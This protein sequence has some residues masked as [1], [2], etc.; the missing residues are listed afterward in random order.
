MNQFSEFYKLIRTKINAG[1]IKEMSWVAIGQLANIIFS[2][3]IVKLLSRM[4]EE[5]YGIYALVITLAV[6]SGILFYGPLAQGFIRF[7][8]HYL[9]LNHAR[10]FTKLIY[11]ILLF[12]ILIFLLI[13]FI[14]YLVIPLIDHSQPAIFF[15]LAGVYIITVKINEF[16]NAVLNLIRKR[17]ENSILQGSEKAFIIMLLFGLIYFKNFMLINVFIILA[18][19]AFFS[20]SIKFYIFQKYLPDEQKESEV[21]K[22]LR[23]EMRANLI[24]YIT[25]F[26]IW[27]FSG[28]LQLNSEKWIIN[29]ILSTADVGI[30]AVMMALVNALIIAP[31]NIISDFST[32]II[33]K[34]YSYL[35]NKKKIK[36]GYQY[37]YINILIVF[38]LTI[39]S[40]IITYFWGKELII[41]ISNAGYSKFWYLLPMFCLGTGLF[42][43]GQALTMHGLALNVPK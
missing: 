8:Y 34:Q 36:I 29:G 41:L 28:W 19:V 38:G 33:F 17:K 27:G 35:M 16:F 10:K 37:I 15:L 13:S 2:F 39:F 31:N 18:I 14:S 22:P 25:P 7:Y 6:F 30:Y 4:G 40:T 12:S 23:L 1:S 20:S 9:E 43:T 5:N 3:I 42:L 26:L 24:Q 32:P 21:G 11:K